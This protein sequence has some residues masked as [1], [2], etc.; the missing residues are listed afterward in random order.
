MPLNAPIEFFK[1]EEKFKSAKTKEEKIAALEEMIRLCPK[2]KSAENMLSQLKSRLAKLKKQKEA[3]AARRALSIPKQGD[4]QVCIIGITQSGK[5]TLLKLLTNARPKISDVPYTTKRP[6]IGTCDFHGVKIQLIEIPSTFR[7]EFM[8][9]AQN[10]DAVILVLKNASEREELVKILSNFRINKPFC[11]VLKEE[12]DA[13]KIKERIWNSLNMIRVYTKEP[14]KKPEKKPLVL[15][16]GSTVRDAVRS[17]HKDFLKFFRFAR[18]WG[19]SKYPGQTF[20]FDYV[21]RDGDIL[22]IHLS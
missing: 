19:S 17:I 16:K 5:S 7:R 15:K 11:E 9:I 8:S 3:K 10:C 14:G 1:A 22:E 13:K 2:H 4:A 21:L 20:G 6:E 12:S 18:V